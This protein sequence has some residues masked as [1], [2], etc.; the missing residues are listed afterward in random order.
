M[1]TPHIEAEK[2]EIATT[3]IMPGDPLRAKFIAENFLE[4]PVQFNSIRN[5]L[6]YSGLYHGKMVSVM[7]SGMG[8]ASMGIYSYELFSKYDVKQIIRIG[9]AGSY[10]EK[11][12]VFDVVLADSAYSESTYALV[13]SGY[14]ENITYPSGELNEKI[15]A[16]AK[17]IE[18]PLVETRVYSTDVYR[19]QPGYDN[20]DYILN[21][22]GCLCVEME[23]F[24]LFHNAR[25]LGKHAACLLTISD[26]AVTKQKTS[27]EQR[28]NAFHDMMKIAL[29]A[30]D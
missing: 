11:L 15:R 17:K 8:M 4:N 26:S 24:A 21:T 13:Q 22:M 12:Q 2:G 18:I 30:L 25:V 9:T 10:T 28:L 1:S 23:S 29:E 5:M 20:S 6:G 7:G 16:A 3:V 14:Q 19:R 27:A